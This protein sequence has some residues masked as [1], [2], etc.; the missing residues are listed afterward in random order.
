MDVLT[1]LLIAVFFFIV[2]VTFMGVI[3]Y[4]QGVSRRMRG[5]AKPTAPE[6]PDLSEVARLMRHLQTQDLVVQMDGKNFVAAH[7]LSPAQ[8]RRLSF[9]SDVLAKWLT[10]PAPEPAAVEAAASEPIPTVAPAPVELSSPFEPLPEP[11]EPEQPSRPGY[12]PPFESDATEPVKPV[13][14]ELPDMMGGMLN[15]IPAP[16][17]AFKSIA[18]QINDILQAHLAGT[19]LES[20]GITLQDGPDRGVMVTLD[21]KQYLG[22]ADV[23]DEEVRYAIRAAVQEWETK[24]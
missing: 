23:P 4:L 20:R 19:P 5:N 1:T 3:W 22:V 10:L 13:S 15:P 9:T 8:Q 21:G 7:E 6:D 14:T 12:T 11:V 17:T 18:M 16:P 2:G 24:K